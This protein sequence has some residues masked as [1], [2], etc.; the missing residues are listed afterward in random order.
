MPIT[1]AI[2]KYGQRNF[3]LTLL[4]ECSSQKEL[5]EKEK[6]FAKDLNTFSPNGYNLKAG[7][8]HGAMAEEV[9]LKIG[10]AHRG[11]K[12][13]I[14][15]RQ[16]LSDAH[17]GLK[18]SPEQKRKVS[19]LKKGQKASDLCYQKAIEALQKEYRLV[20]PGG[21]EFSGVNLKRFC[22]QNGYKYIPMW[23]VATGRSK[24][25]KGWRHGGASV[26]VARLPSKQQV[27]VQFSGSA[28]KPG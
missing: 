20:D 10:Q 16:R 21:K 8:G 28:P 2:K 22:I 26:E 5:N 14:E 9:K 1:L 23:E 19:E 24:Q 12:F 7:N 6:Q 3:S 13:S 11:R 25:Y 18:W 15:R 4:C 17:K 27:G